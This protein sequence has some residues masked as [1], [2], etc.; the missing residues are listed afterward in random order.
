MSKCIKMIKNIFIIASVS[1]L[2]VQGSCKKDDSSRILAVVEKGISSVGFYTTDGNHI[3]TLKL[4]TFPHEMRLSPDRKYAY[5]TN[6][7]SLRYKDSVMG[8]ETI[9]VINLHS[10][11]KEENISL[12]PFRRPHGIDIDTQTG[13]LAVGVEN[14]D[15]V[16]LIDPIR[17][18]ILKTFDCYGKTPHMV[19]ISKGAGWIYVSNVQ[20]ANLVGINVNT[21][22]HFSVDV[23]YKPQESVISPDNTLLF[24]G[25]DEHISVI[26]LGKKAV[27]NKIPNG[28]NR[29]E[30]IENENLL[31]FSSTKYGIGFADAKTFRMLYHIDIPYKPYSLH[32]SENNS[33]AYVAA[34]E[35]DIIYEVSIADKK[36]SR[37]FKLKKGVRPDPVMDF[38][39]Y[40][41]KQ[42]YASGKNKLPEFKKREID[43]SFFK[44]YQIKSAD[45][46]NDKKPDL[47]AVSD[48]LPEVVWYENPTWDKH[49]LSS[50]TFRNIDISPHDIDNDGDV[51]IVL[52]CR[53]NSKD[54]EKGGYIYWLE[55]TR[56]N[57]YGEWEK[58][59]IDSVPTSHRLKWADIYGNGKKVLINLPLMGIGAKQPDYSIPLKLYSYTIPDDPVNQPWVKTCIDS[60]LHMAHGLF[61]YR[62]DKDLRDD[63]LTASFEGVNLYQYGLKGKSQWTKT[64][65]TKG[66]SIDNQ[67][68]GSSEIV[69]GKLGYYE[70]LFI[71][72]IEPWH[73]NQLVYYIKGNENVWKRHVID[74]SF[75]DGH[76]LACEDVNFDGYDEIIAGHRGENFNLFIYQYQPKSKTWIRAHIDKGGMSAAGVCV[77]DANN[78]G[79]SD[80]AACGS[81][82]QNIAVYF[83]S[84]EEN[85]IELSDSKR[86]QVPRLNGPWVQIVGR[87]QLE[88]WASPEAEPVDF[89]IFQADNGDWQLISCIRKTT[90]PGSGRLLYRWSSPELQ[91][92]NW[93]P[94]GIFLSSRPEWEHAEGKVQA[95]FHVKE[96]DKHYLFY[97]SRGCHL[98]T[99]ENGLNFEP[100]EKKVIFSMGRDVCIL[101]DRDGSGKWIAY[102]TSPERGINSA[103]GDHTIRA[104][105]AKKLEGPWSETATEIPPITSPPVGYKFLYA[106]S[107]L[108]IKR[109]NYYYRFEQLHVYVSKDPMKWSG[110]PIA[111]LAPEDPIKLLAPEIVTYNGQDYL[112][113]YQWQNDDPRGIFIAPLVWE[114]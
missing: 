6:N 1:L 107:P 65:L 17:K 60:S 89:T 11:E 18:K 49:I 28:A 59:Y 41:K 54:S 83:N 78:D 35:Q 50:S 84:K 104:R 53:F 113:A 52:A 14:P 13:Y 76:A 103:T 43:T 109:G 20:S 30:L 85:K 24:V 68:R 39:T 88:K 100:V 40:K 56:E 95:P 58:H 44:A 19:T 27:I 48:R 45:L 25:C 66:L 61:V 92:T 34:E 108:V 79:F 38:K 33:K 12:H 73:G 63:I 55:N 71:A 64:N 2:L 37:Q 98:L 46:N 51:D 7:G 74:T 36:I 5:I 112:L 111:N 22:E 15:K 101:D 29:M 102:Y 75:N 106:E 42:A 110:P 62:W 47:I 23:G 90:H 81:L 97:N 70:K 21:G 80:V 31:V 57:L 16:L 105:T 86:P 93:K 4:D 8:G 9:S 87:P 99:S 67:Y 94:E 82:T 96:M 32:L 72:T 10:L 69:I 114:K 3:K 91:L 77:F 26:D